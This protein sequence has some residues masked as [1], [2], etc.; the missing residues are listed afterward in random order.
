MFFEIHFQP[1]LL[2]A[3]IFPSLEIKFIF[4][5]K[6]YLTTVLRDVSTIATIKCHT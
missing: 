5:N 2:G 3:R 1:A 6:S 4:N